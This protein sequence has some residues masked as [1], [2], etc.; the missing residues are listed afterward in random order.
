MHPHQQRESSGGPMFSPALGRVSLLY[1]PF[2]RLCGGVLVV[3][4]YLTLISRDAK[5]LFMYFYHVVA[6]VTL[7]T[8][9]FIGFL[10]LF[11]Y[12]SRYKCFF[13]SIFEKHFLL[14]FKLPFGFLNCF[15]EKFLIL[16]KSNFFSS[17][18]ICELCVLFKKLVPNLCLKFLRFSPNFF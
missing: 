13:R 18:I 10:V 4:I 1:S 7:F 3:L 9:A 8:C 14:D 6:Y 2:W 11:F 15:F 17:F 12:N 16:I 5:H